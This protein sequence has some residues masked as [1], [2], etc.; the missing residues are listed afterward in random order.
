MPKDKAV[1][2]FELEKTMMVFL[3]EMT[4]KYDLPDVSKAVRCLI[5]YARDIE[6]ARDDIFAE[7]RCLSCD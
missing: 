7:I 5:N 4:A 1:Y 2:S 3:E 6:E